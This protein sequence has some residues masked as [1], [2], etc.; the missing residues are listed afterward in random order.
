MMCIYPKIDGNWWKMTQ[1]SIH[2]RFFLEVTKCCGGQ[3]LPCPK[4]LWPP[5]P[6]TTSYNVYSW[7]VQFVAP[8]SETQVWI[9]Y[10]TRDQSD[11]QCLL[12]VQ[13]LYQ[14]NMDGYG[15]HN[16]TKLTKINQPTALMM[17]S[18]VDQLTI[19]QLMNHFGQVSNWQLQTKVFWVTSMPWFIIMFLICYKL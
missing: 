9:E 14:T 13:T 15:W 17:S 4:K 10:S 7:G 3:S 2:P 11:L 5:N 8:G 6:S 18:Y 12:W 16:T 19:N 1:L